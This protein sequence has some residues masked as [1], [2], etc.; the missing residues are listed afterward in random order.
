M[1]A[2]SA[3]WEKRFIE[4]AKL[5]STWSKDGVGVGAVIIDGQ[6]CVRGVGY[7][8]FPRGVNDDEERYKEKM[9]KLKLVVHAEANA[10]M[11]ATSDIRETALFCTRYPCSDCAKMIIQ[12][13]IIYV[14]S[15]PPKTE[16]HW[17]ED[18]EFTRQMFKEAGIMWITM[19]VP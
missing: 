12:K 8:G 11:N 9:V 19:E 5:V 16:G 1:H 14:Y 15:P 18:A 17:A 2:F 10:V 3:K 6:R 7:N 4:M 13:G